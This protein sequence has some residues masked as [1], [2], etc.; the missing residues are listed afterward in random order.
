MNIG[1]GADKCVYLTYFIPHRT[2]C[3]DKYVFVI[4]LYLRFETVD[5]LCTTDKCII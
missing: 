1:T 4:I 5:N 3:Y 2:T